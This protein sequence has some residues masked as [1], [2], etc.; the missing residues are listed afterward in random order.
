MEGVEGILFTLGDHLRFK[1][2]GGKLK[3]QD[4]DCL[5]DSIVQYFA[6]QR[7]ILAY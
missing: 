4:K 6:G 7:Y 3:L 5:K 2:G 1:G